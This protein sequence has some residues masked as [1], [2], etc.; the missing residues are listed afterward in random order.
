MHLS[1]QPAAAL[2]DNFA[3]CI[4]A[5]APFHVSSYFEKPPFALPP[6]C[7]DT[8]TQLRTKVTLN[9]ADLLSRACLRSSKA[10]LL[11]ADVLQTQG[12]FK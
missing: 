1:L 8:L 5:H 11:A 2:F 9:R 12:S 3:G 7:S 10:E 6:L 4:S